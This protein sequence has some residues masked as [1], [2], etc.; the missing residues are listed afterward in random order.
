MLQQIPATLQ[1]RISQDSSERNTF[2]QE[3]LPLIYKTWQEAVWL[4][5]RVVK[6]TN[7]RKVK[8]WTIS[9]KV[10]KLRN[11]CSQYWGTGSPR[12]I[13]KISMVKH[14]YIDSFFHAPF[15]KTTKINKYIYKNWI[16][17]GKLATYSVIGH[18]FLMPVALKPV[19]RRVLRKINTWIT[20]PFKIYS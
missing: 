10:N 2:E 3:T 11:S 18:V 9:A 14:Y 5:L 12:Q 6:P 17:R 4:Q 13:G 8:L 1:S 19:L 7:S 16:K 20:L 15:S